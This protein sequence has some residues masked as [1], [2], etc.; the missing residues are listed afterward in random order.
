MAF[1]W[2]GQAAVMVIFLGFFETFCTYEE[3]W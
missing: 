1:C 3:R 2:F